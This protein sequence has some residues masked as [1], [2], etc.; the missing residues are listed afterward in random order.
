MAIAGKWERRSPLRR[1]TLFDFDVYAVCGDGDLM[2]GVSG[3]AASIAGHQRLDNLC[4]IY[5]N[6]HISIDGRTEITYSDDVAARFMGYGWNVT[7]VGDANDLGLLTR[8]FERS[9]RRSGRPTLIIVDSHIGWGSPHKQDTAAAHGEP[10]GEDEVRETKRTY[11]WPE[12]AQFLVPEGVY[13]HFAEGIGARGERLRAEW[14]ERLGATGDPAVARADRADAAA[15]A[16]RGLGRRHPELRR[17]REGD[18][19]PQGVEPGAER[20]RAR[21]CRGCSAARP[22]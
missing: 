6:N 13:E 18:R 5:D 17:R 9:A 15:R 11:G 7:R 8:A 2:E 12:D 10:L 3:E 21:G 14:E 20:D 1:A 16:A 4:W 19:D 22:T